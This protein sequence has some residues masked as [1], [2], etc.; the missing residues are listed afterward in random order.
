MAE[1]TILTALILLFRTALL[2]PPSMASADDSIP[3]RT[4]DALYT[5]AANPSLVAVD[6]SASHSNVV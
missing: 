2:P 3:H 1:Q 6:V 5:D 4:G